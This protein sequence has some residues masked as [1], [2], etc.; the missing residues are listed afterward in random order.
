MACF[1]STSSTQ[2]HYLVNTWGA[3]L[4]VYI[5]SLFFSPSPS[6][7]PGCVSPGVIRRVHVTATP[8]RLKRQV[9]TSPLAAMVSPLTNRR[10][11]M[12]SSAKKQTNGTKE[13][14]KEEML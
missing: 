3:R 2:Y 4:D 10:Q 5:R 13:V 6:R 12:T 7:H 8:P 1:I 14:Y 11:Y 9:M